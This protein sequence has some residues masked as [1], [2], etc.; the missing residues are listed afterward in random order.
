MS[1]RIR[2]MASECS[3]PVCDRPVRVAGYC[4]GHYYRK[5]M[6]KSVDTALR[7]RRVADEVL[8]RDSQGNKFCTLGNHWEPPS[9]FLTDPKRADK[10]HTACNE[11]TRQSRLLAQYGISVETYRAMEIAQGDSCAVCRIPSDGKAWHID[12][13]H[14]CCS[15]EKSCGHCIR[16]LLCHNCNVGLGH[17]RDNVELLLAATNYLNGAS[18]G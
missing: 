14:A 9:K 3:T 4:S 18:V 11:C 16:G 12:H 5:R 7:S 6:G 13:D 10:L 8:V 2:L 1:C 15:G 17:F